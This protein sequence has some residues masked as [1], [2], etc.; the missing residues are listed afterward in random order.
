MNGKKIFGILLVFVGVFLLLGE[1]GMIDITIG[2]FISKYWPLILI[3]IGIYKLLTDSISKTAGII[4]IIIGGIFQLRNFQ[5]F[6]IFEYNLFWPIVI[7][8]IGIWILLSPKRDNWKVSSK[9]TLNTFALFSGFNIKNSSQNF[10]GG[11]I[12]VVFGGADVDLR[13]ANILKE[14]EA[15]IDILIAF[16]GAEIFVPQGWNVII[17]GVPIFGGWE[18]ETV[19]NNK[20]DSPTLIINSFVMFGG[21]EV[22][23]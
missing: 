4:L 16:G 3:V 14:Q 20:E 12:T 23:N 1:T 19:N 17:K 10:K 8:L 13:D 21:F 7:I 5:Y 6:N 2:E 9:D 18:N 11:N 15:R 22:K